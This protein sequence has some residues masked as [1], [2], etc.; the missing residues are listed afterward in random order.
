MKPIRIQELKPTSSIYRY[1]TQEIEL[2]PTRI[3]FNDCELLIPKVETI[4][5]EN[6]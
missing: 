6:K 1:F 2:S 5:I 4:K 3:N